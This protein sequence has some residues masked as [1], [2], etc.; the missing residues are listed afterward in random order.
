MRPT[1]SSTTHRRDGDGTIR[2]PHARRLRVTTHTSSRL[3]RTAQAARCPTGGNLV[4]W[5][6]RPTQPAVALHPRELPASTVPDHQRWHVSSGYA[7]P[8]HDGT[9]WCRIS[10]LLLC[11]T[12]PHQQ[13][14]TPQLGGLRRRLALHTRRLLDASQLT[15]PEP[16]GTPPPA[17][18]PARPVI[19]LLHLLYLARRPVE[20]LQ[21]VAQTRARHRCPHPVR[22]PHHPAGQ[23]ILLPATFGAGQLAAPR[24]VMAVYDLTRLPATEQQRWR[25]QR[26]PAHAAAPTP[27]DLALSDFDLFDP[28]VHH[29][30]IHSR[31]PRTGPH[32]NG[33]RR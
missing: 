16:R 5:Y 15:A 2:R 3:L 21:C 13:E 30:H 18:R 27:A 1:T 31:L 7:H 26:C 8:A 14:T 29:Q 12:Q 17:C 20:E 32:R 28:L 33:A 10:H 25:T 19:Q 6:A 24:A 9:P 11:P 23:W 22:D 4:E